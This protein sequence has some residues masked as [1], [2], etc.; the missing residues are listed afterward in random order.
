M[1]S[2]GASEGSVHMHI[3]KINKSFLKK[4]RMKFK[5]TKRGTKVQNKGIVS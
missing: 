3:H 5:G 2:S 1:P 4:K